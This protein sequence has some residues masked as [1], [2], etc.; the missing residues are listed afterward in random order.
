MNPGVPA[1]VALERTDAYPW[2]MLACPEHDLP[3]ER[4]EDVDA[5]DTRL[6]RRSP[7]VWYTCNEGCHLSGQ[8]L[9]DD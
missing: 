2:Q 7:E 9:V 1:P 4:H 5:L 8:E 6:G 3:V